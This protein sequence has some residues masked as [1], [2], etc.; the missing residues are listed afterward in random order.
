M[1][2]T[3]SGRIGVFGAI[4]LFVLAVIA[5]AAVVWGPKLVREGRA[6]GGPLID[7]ARAEGRLEKLDERF[8]FTPPEDR[9]ITEDRLEAFLGIRADLQPR[10][11]AWQSLIEEVEKTGEESW[12]TAREV[13]VATRDVIIAQIESLERN[14]MSK[15]EFR[16]LEQQVYDEWLDRGTAGP[17][18]AQLLEATQDDLGFLEQLEREIGPGRAVAEMRAR[19]ERRLEELRGPRPE[20]GPNDALLET[21]R[22]RIAALR[23]DRYREVHENMVR[24]GSDGVRIEI[25]GDGEKG[26]GPE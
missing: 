6:M 16:W 14:Q 8:P 17:A 2:R 7:L 3:Q 21:H 24:G 10:Y 13:I 12:D 20:V 19:L 25:G 4:A 15:A 11:E 5:T 1:A 18:Q 26:S 9:G 23:L 22:E